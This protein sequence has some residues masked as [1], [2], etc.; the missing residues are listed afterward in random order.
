M[1]KINI[2]NYLETAPC[3]VKK[4]LINKVKL[5]LLFKNTI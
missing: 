5:K 3:I 2:N 1:S 4:M